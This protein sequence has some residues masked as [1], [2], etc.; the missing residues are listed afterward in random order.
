MCLFG[1]KHTEVPE[2]TGA[3]GEALA[4]EHLRKNGYKIRARNQRPDGHE[5]IDIVCETR[6]TRIFAEVKTRTQAPMGPMKYG[7]PATAVT[8]EKRRHLINAAHAYNQAH[9][10]KKSIRMDVIEVYLAPD[11]TLLDLHHIEDA[12]RT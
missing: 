3:R 10:T 12:F 8:H 6:K 2:S 9:P 7:S 4:A 1:R 5:E 11:G